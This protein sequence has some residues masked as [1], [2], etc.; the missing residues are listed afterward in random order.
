MPIQME[1][2]RTQAEAKCVCS[3]CSE[4][5]LE[6]GHV[7][8][9]RVEQVPQWLVLTRAEARGF[10][11]PLLPPPA[12]PARLQP[13]PPLPSLTAT[14]HPPTYGP[15]NGLR[16]P[17]LEPAMTRATSRDDDGDADATTAVDAGRRA[18]APGLNVATPQLPA[19]SWFLA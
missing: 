13:L 17:W 11:A 3:D 2:M 6:T 18:G 8:R 7:G 5:H 12:C 9:G 14:G 15:T 16:A 4:I 1:G 10:V 19:I